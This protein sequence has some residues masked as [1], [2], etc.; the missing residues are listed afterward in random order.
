MSTSLA[1]SETPTIV[2]SVFPVTRFRIPSLTPLSS[3]TPS[4]TSTQQMSSPEQ[5]PDA[6][7]DPIISEE[8]PLTPLPSTFDTGD[9]TG[10]ATTGTNQ[11]DE[12]DAPLEYVTEEELR[13]GTPAVAANTDT[14]VM[15]QLNTFAFPP[16]VPPPSMTTAPLNPFATPFQ[17]QTFPSSFVHHPQ[18]PAPIPASHSELSEMR[19]QFVLLQRQFAQLENRRQ[20]DRDTINDLRI[21]LRR[22]KT[23]R[24]NAQLQA[25][26]QLRPTH[27]PLG[28]VFGQEPS[29]SV[30]AD[31]GHQLPDDHEP[32]IPLAPAQPPVAP[33]VPSPAPV[34]F[35]KIKV[36]MPPPFDGDPAKLVAFLHACNLLFRAK[37]H[38]DYQRI[39]VALSYFQEGSALRFAQ[40]RLNEIQE[41]ETWEDFKA[42]VI[43][44]FGGADLAEDARVALEAL[45]QGKKLVEDYN[46][47]FNSHASRAEYNDNALVMRYKK[48]L[49]SNIL[50]ALSHAEVIPKTL[51]EWQNRAAAIERHEREMR[52]YLPSTTLATNKTGHDILEE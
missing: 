2:Q 17:Q 19:Q 51:Q 28:S 27:H 33:P 7:V 16:R 1:N 43:D 44:V 37:P 21:Q 36:A 39:V 48:G 11:Q 6:Q 47:E 25:M 14:E 5:I 20:Q 24:M 15:E 32:P 31:D 30:E 18:Q 22:E 34:E 8:S 38:T 12:E 13:T 45:Y 26:S 9:H 40:L 41:T 50:R 49:N 46:I 29:Q 3:L 4:S 42:E 23:A 35:T 10:H 52:Q